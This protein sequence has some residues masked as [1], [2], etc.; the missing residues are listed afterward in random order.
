MP[1]E[2][3]RRRLSAPGRESSL[4]QGGMSMA[5]GSLPHRSVAAAVALS[6]S[7]TDIV[8]IPSLPKRSPAES[9]IAQALVGLDGVTV[10]QYGSLAID[11]AR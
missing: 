6:M 1:T 8:T 7:S 2:T 3:D 10:G 9:M 4:V 11:L 5:I